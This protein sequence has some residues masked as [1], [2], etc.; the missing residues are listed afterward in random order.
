LIWKKTDITSP[1]FK[2]N[3]HPFY[4]FL[5]NEKPVWR[6]RLPDK[7]DAYLLSRYDDA[8]ASLRDTRFVKNL[9]A[10][11]HG[12]NE[13]PF[14][15]LRIAKMLDKLIYSRNNSAHNPIRKEDPHEYKPD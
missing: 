1:A 8:S 3:P 14:K 12:P 11:P 9:R 7:R 5:R 10:V 15:P 2:A 13:K 4:R 6:M